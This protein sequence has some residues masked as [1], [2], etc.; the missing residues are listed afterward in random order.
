[1]ACFMNESPGSSTGGKD[2]RDSKK[3]AWQ[4]IDK[5]RPASKTAACR[6]YFT[7]YVK[8]VAYIPALHLPY[9]IDSQ[10]LSRTV[11]LSCLGSPIN[12]IRLIPGNV[13]TI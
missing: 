5:K 2:V 10:S 11:E 4:K 13:V 1:M 9:P 12:T 7:K 6:I 8:R 3:R